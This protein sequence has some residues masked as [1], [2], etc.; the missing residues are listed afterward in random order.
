M[1]KS[2]IANFPRFR[3]NAD[4]QDTCELQNWILAQQDRSNQ[5]NMNCDS[6]AR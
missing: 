6:I 1:T 4:K 5:N 3:L 2:A